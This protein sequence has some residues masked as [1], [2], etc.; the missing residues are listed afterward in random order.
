MIVVIYTADRLNKVS[1]NGKLE[2]NSCDFVPES[3]LPLSLKLECKYVL[4]RNL[5]GGYFYEIEV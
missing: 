2:K 1:R 5:N 4:R 3:K